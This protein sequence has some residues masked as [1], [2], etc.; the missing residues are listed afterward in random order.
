MTSTGI[1]FDDGKSHKVML[2]YSKALQRLDLYMDDL[3]IVGHWINMKDMAFPDGKA[4]IG[5]SG[6]TSKALPCFPRVHHVVFL[7][8]LCRRLDVGYHTKSATNGPITA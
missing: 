4:W 5:I 7:N 6:S 2:L 1:D 3:H 8:S